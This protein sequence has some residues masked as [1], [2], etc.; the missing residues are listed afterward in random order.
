MEVGLELHAAVR[1]ATSA[2]VLEVYPHACFRTLAR[3]ATPPNK[4]TVAGSARPV[5]LLHQRGIAAARL[6][7]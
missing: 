2:T 4:S 3:G 7:I 6:A 1:A 5:E